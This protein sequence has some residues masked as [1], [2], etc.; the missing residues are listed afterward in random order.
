M[1]RYDAP[2]MLHTGSDADTDHADSD[3][4]FPPSS[5]PP[6]STNPNKFRRPQP[7]RL[8]SQTAPNTPLRT[9][10]ASRHSSDIESPSSL[11]RPSYPARRATVTDVPDG[12][13]T[14]D[15]ISE[16]EARSKFP[17]KKR[18]SAYRQE[19]RQSAYLSSRN[20]SRQ[21]D[22][23]S[24][25]RPRHIRRLTGMGVAT[26][27]NEN[28]PGRQHRAKQKW[29][30]LK[31]SMGIGVP[32]KRKEEVTDLKKSNELI[33]CLLAGYPAALIL[34][35][36]FQRDERDV[37]KVPVLM[38]QL[39]FEITSVEKIEDSPDRHLKFRI[40]L[41]YGN[42]DIRMNWEILRYIS[43]FVKLHSNYKL[44]DSTT[45]VMR[46]GAKERVKLP[47][48]PPTAR[49]Y[50][51]K[52]R[53]AFGDADDLSDEDAEG[54][55]GHDGHTDSTPGQNKQKKRR[56]HSR[57]LTRSSNAGIETPQANSIAGLDMSGN[58][59][60]MA[61][62]RE[63]LN[64]ALSREFN[65]YLNELIQWT[66]FQSGSNRLCRFLEISALGMKL[67]A[68][69][70]Y[71]GKEGSMKI[72]S[73]KIKERGK[74]MGSKWFLVRDSFIA[75]VN[76]PEQTTLIDVFLIDPDF[77]MNPRPRIRDA[78]KPKEMAKTAKNSAAH[79]NMHLI[80]LENSERRL[81]L[82]AKNERQQDQFAES[83]RK[84]SNQSEW[85][86]KHRFDSFAPKRSNVFAE[87]LVDA[88]DYMW[89]LSQAVDL[90]K[91]VIYIHDWWLSPEL[92]LRRPPAANMEWRLDNL[93]RRKAQQG[94]KIYVLLYRNIN[95]AIPIESE[96]SKARLLDLHPNVQVQRS[97]NQVR[98]G[99]F[100]WAHHEK[101]CVV[102]DTVA[103]CG[104][105]DLCF[106]RWDTPDHRV[107][108]DKPVGFDANG[109]VQTQ[110]DSSNDP[111][112]FQVWP[113]KDYSNPR[114]ADFSSLDRPWEEMYNRERTARM[115]WHDM[116]MQLVGQPARDLSRHFVQ[117]WNCL[118]RQR[119]KHTR[120]TP[121]LLPPPEF[122]KDQLQK[123]NCEGTCEVQMLRSACEWSMGTPKKDE[124]SI[125]N[126]YVK[127]IET[128]QHFI[129]IENQFFITSCNV[130]G[131][132]IRN[133]IGDALVERIIRAHENEE[134]WHAV[135]MIPLMP[136]FESPIHTADASSIRLIMQCQYRSICRE[137]TSIFGRLKA[138]GI[139]PEDYIRFYS[140]RAWGKIGPTKAL[141]TE[142]LYIHGKCMIVDDRYVIIG[143][144]NINE[145][146][147]LGSRDSEV[148][149]IVHDTELLES[150]MAGEPYQVGRFPHTLRM[151][152]MREHLG[153]DTDRVRH[154]EIAQ[155][156]RDLE[157]ILNN[158]EMPGA[159]IRQDSTSSLN[160]LSENSQNTRRRSL[161]F[162]NDDKPRVQTDGSVP[163][164]KDTTNFPEL[165]DVSKPSDDDTQFTQS[166]PSKEFVSG[167][168]GNEN[169]KLTSD[170]STEKVAN[171][172]HCEDGALSPSMARKR[173]TSLL[174]LPSREHS[175]SIS[176]SERRRSN[177]ALPPSMPPRLQSQDLG[178]P[179]LSQLPP[180]P[181]TDDLD[182][183]GPPLRRV[184]SSNSAEFLRT[185]MTDL[186]L[187]IVEDDCMKD[188]LRDEFLLDIWQKVAENNTK[189][190]RQVFRCQ[191]DDLVTTFDAYHAWIDYNDRFNRAQGLPK[192]VKSDETRDRSN[193][194]SGPPGAGLQTP[195]GSVDT[196]GSTL[197]INHDEEKN[198][199]A[200]NTPPKRSRAISVDGS[201]SIVSEGEGLPIP[202]QRQDTQESR[203]SNP[204]TGESPP[205]G[206]ADEKKYVPNGSA[207]I[208][209]NSNTN[210]TT[211]RRRRTTTKSSGSFR[212][213][214]PIL[215]KAEAEELLKL[216]QGHLVVFPNNW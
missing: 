142:Q 59:G 75:C 61:P 182:I 78:T 136:G 152:L 138:A 175:S 36:N 60:S 180:L 158:T 85:A 46:R 74:D 161:N 210:G 121:V 17:W 13:S 185:F 10:F 49:N 167:P 80:N 112:K 90:A 187:P 162:N 22:S 115:P 174:E 176:N 37:K 98:Q 190:F 100:Y 208:T 216:V 41:E 159:G 165:G 99:A 211:R 101:I 11:Y 148:A 183:G 128:S 179:T 146:S 193:T 151:R 3:G 16:D 31:A 213:T 170:I 66:A 143:S 150:K 51:R 205:S 139:V 54:D 198:E 173:A 203:Q 171:G 197:E 76:S 94:V 35:S 28:T 88:R 114:V 82:F 124:C 214:D 209:D 141:T 21:D 135:I 25:P 87:W 48:F 44:Q 155:S 56:G 91:R 157:N 164:G 147:M 83:I 15:G 126:A 137:E 96:F 206:D 207:N 130:D 19:R 89:R 177:S 113:G 58:D 4:E 71:H 45:R 30:H 32:K 169:G 186:Q 38:E 108:D 12:T 55:E 122:P 144:A 153:I 42:D 117:R 149:A 72:A 212:A 73:K 104:G 2:H 145:R 196:S 200:R 53:P 133:K 120:P 116:G 97:P 1:P 50:W 33:A 134:D 119:R 181:S 127:L 132:M 202:P 194:H 178:L 52:W 40:K 131:T 129:Y 156:K 154:G 93:L 195:I 47:K 86:K 95:Q 65:N 125:Q 20:P 110:E 43:D 107:T 24:R 8:G 163:S 64:E 7:V 184:F 27:S 109:R 62:R 68:D 166:K 92:F 67:A 102:D 172:L 201:P 6:N 123:S 18:S 57:Q 192:D 103:F 77:K 189:L 140:L 5:S 70:Q 215:Q 204:Q 29:D 106:G 79:P 188:P 26:G 39:K 118:V 69:C 168:P 23:E 105:V 9:T 111:Q 160:I 81:G 199:H 14:Q 84:M 191:P 63:N 34:A